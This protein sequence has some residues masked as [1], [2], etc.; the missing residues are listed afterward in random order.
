MP[1]LFAVHPGLCRGHE[2]SAL[3]GVSLHT[4][5]SVFV[6]ERAVVTEHPRTQQFGEG[7]V[8]ADQ[9][10]GLQSLGSPSGVGRLGCLDGPLG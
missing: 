1:H 2:Q 6:V 7:L 3:G 9:C 10:G 4:P 8:S 5:L